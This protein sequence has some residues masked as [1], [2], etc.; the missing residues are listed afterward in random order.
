MVEYFYEQM[1]VLFSLIFRHL[2]S[3]ML[4]DNKEYSLTSHTETLI[5][6]FGVY[7]EV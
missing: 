6:N 1:Y 4:L 3:I 5:C 2:E 7:R